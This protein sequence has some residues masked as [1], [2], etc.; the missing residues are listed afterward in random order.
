MNIFDKIRVFFDNFDNSFSS[1]KKG[2]PEPTK[3]EKRQLAA[4]NVSDE[5][6]LYD[7]ITDGTIQRVFDRDEWF[8]AIE[9]ANK[10]IAN[11]KDWMQYFLVLYMLVRNWPHH[12]ASYYIETTR[13][14]VDPF[15]SSFEDYDK[16][17]WTEQ[18][19]VEWVEGLNDDV[20]QQVD[21]MIRKWKRKGLRNRHIHLLLCET[22]ADFEVKT[23][24]ARRENSVSLLHAWRLWQ[25]TKD[26]EEAYQY[27]KRE[28]KKARG[29]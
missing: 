14:I 26:K 5:D 29:Y 21:N 10:A 24:Q 2:P 15:G 22:R 25:E 17:Q 9:S 20:R 13:S 23:E 3:E 6:E 11:E 27:F 18:E 1:S 28:N 19:M 16:P 4:M 12:P 7:L 8:Q